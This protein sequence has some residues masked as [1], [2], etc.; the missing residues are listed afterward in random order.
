MLYM[1]LT[2]K[3]IEAARINMKNINEQSP[4]EFS[5]L[6]VAVAILGVVMAYIFNG[7]ADWLSGFPYG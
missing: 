2:K 5:L 1:Q 3:N 7:M 6:M 4:M